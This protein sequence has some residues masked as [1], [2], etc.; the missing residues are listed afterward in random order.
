MLICQNQLQLSLLFPHLY[1]SELMNCLYSLSL[2]PNFT[3]MEILKGRLLKCRIKYI[4]QTFSED[5]MYWVC[6]RLDAGRTTWAAS[7]R[8]FQKLPR[9]W[10]QPAPSWTGCWPRLSPS[11]T[12]ALSYISIFIC[13]HKF[14]VYFLLAEVFGL[15]PSAKPYVK[16][17]LL[18]CVFSVVNKIIHCAHCVHVLLKSLV[19]QLA[20]NSHSKWL[21]VSTSF[22]LISQWHVQSMIGMGL[23]LT[24]KHDIPYYK[25][26][27]NK[28]EE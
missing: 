13:C 7:V 12:S 9:V 19:F 26:L 22:I 21:I 17:Y 27:I 2:V 4:Q 24:A 14:R 20:W 28:R 6:M 18:K 15:L 10:C 11:V 16:V 25:E 5:L 8:S 1:M 3:G 23:L